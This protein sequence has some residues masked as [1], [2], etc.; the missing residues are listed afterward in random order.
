MTM[1]IRYVFLLQMPDPGHRTFAKLRA[2]M[3]SK[4]I[5]LVSVTTFSESEVL[6]LHVAIL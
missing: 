5:S 1:I 4:L 2:S 3:F 6:M